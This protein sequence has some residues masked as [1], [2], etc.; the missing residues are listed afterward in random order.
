MTKEKLLEILNKKIEEA[1]K[2]FAYWDSKC[3]VSF[4]KLD[5]LKDLLDELVSELEAEESEKGEQKNGWCRYNTWI[6]I[7]IKWK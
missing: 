5:V 2:D 7:V 4:T 3:K 6:N 1:R